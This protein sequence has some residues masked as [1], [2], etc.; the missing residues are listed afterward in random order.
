[1]DIDFYRKTDGSLGNK[2]YRKPTHTNLYLYQN[3]HHRHANKQLVLASLIPRA[4]VLCDQDSHNLELEFLTTAFKD[5]GYNSQ[6]IQA[7]EPASGVA[8]T[9]DKP[10]WTAYIPYTQ[11]ACGQLSRMLAKHIKSE[12]SLFS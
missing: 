2:V 8:K 5:K 3:S 11:I 9:K 4:T 1:M 7:M 6:Q 10:N 12:V